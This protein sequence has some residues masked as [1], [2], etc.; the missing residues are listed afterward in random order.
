M[1]GRRFSKNKLVLGDLTARVVNEV[2]DWIVGQYECQEELK[3]INNY[4]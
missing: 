1:S 2:I 4:W 3:A